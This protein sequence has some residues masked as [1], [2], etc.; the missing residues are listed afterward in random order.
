LSGR[1][2]RGGSP[3]LVMESRVQLLLNR[4]IQGQMKRISPSLDPKEGYSYPQVEDIT[5]VGGAEELLERLVAEGLLF[6]ETCGFLACCPNCGSNGLRGGGSEGRWRCEA[7]GA[8]LE[9]G[10]VRLRPLRCYGIGEEGVSQASK[11]LIANPIINFLHERGYRTESPG[12]LRG[13]SDV[14]HRFD[15][16]AFSGGTDEGTLVVDFFVSDA[17]IGEGKVKAMFAKVFDAT[18]LK[19]VLVAFPG[20][21]E[22]ARKLAEQYRLSFVETT[23]ADTLWKK[24]LSV[25]PPVDDFGYKSLDV[26]TLLSLPDHLRKTATVVSSLGV[27]TAEEI[28][29]GTSRARAVESGYLNQLVRMG[30]LKKEREGRRVLFS[31]VS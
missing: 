22:D 1:R 27:A 7:C 14:R 25:I 4:F 21:T 8:D 9:E 3:G 18:P 15:I 24:L 6:S 2:P 30:Y 31:V 13:E 28:A 23:E 12:T 11:W 17:P 29:E 19:S 16:V 10:Q 20:L 26:M 5:G